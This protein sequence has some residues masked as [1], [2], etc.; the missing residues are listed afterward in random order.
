MIGGLAPS[1]YILR[2]N[3]ETEEQLSLLNKGLEPI[4]PNIDD[5][6][7]SHYITVGFLREDNFNGFF[8]NRKTALLDAIEEVMGEKK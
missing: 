3:Q 5:I 1:E 6:F 7:S 8:Y 4:S 2:F